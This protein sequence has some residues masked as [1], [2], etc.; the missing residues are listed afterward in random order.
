MQKIL[1]YF[2]IQRSKDRIIQKTGEEATEVVIAA[3]NKS[4]ER[5]VSKV[6]DLWFHS[7]ILLASSNITIGEIIEELK[8]RSYRKGSY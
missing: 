2:T 3:K 5:L 7:L 4:R 6:A 1:C 8:K